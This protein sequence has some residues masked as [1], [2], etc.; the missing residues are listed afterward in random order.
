MRRLRP[1]LATIAFVLFLILLVACTVPEAGPTPTPTQTPAATVEP[2]ALPTAIPISI[3]EPIPLPTTVPNQAALIKKA[4]RT[5]PVN[6]VIDTQ[7]LEHGVVPWWFRTLS[8]WYKYTSPD[9]AF[10]VLMRG[11]IAPE[12]ST[13][14]ELLGPSHAVAKVVKADYLMSEIQAVTY[15][16]VPALTADKSTPEEVLKSLDLAQLGGAAAQVE[17]VA[18]TGIQLNGFPGRDLLIKIATKDKPDMKTDWHVRFYIV[19]STVY[20]LTFG[21]FGKSA[22]ETEERFLNSFTLHVSTK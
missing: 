11:G 14:N 1:L 9:G 19:G 12:E 6:F 3:I 5:D 15:F 18:D 10:S 17:V 13:L 7:Q 21:G 20:Q 8:T 22:H 16:E 4:T 2:T